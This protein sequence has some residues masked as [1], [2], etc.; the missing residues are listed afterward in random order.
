[1]LSLVFIYSYWCISQILVYYL[2]SQH[3][4]VTNEDYAQNGLAIYDA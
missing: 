2:G 4:Q 1:M 3:H